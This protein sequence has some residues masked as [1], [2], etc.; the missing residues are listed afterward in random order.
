MS[1]VIVDMHVHFATPYDKEGPK[2]GCHGAEG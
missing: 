1:D 2:D